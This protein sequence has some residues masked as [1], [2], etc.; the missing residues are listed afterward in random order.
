MK[1]RI[2]DKLINWMNDPR[3]KPLLVRG[4]RQVGKTFSIMEFGR[5]HYAGDL[6]VLNFEKNPE[7]NLIFDQNL[8]PKR[9]L[10][11]LE[12][13]LN[14][15]IRPGRDLIFFDEI[16]DCPK[17][18]SSLRYFYEEVQDLHVIA[19]GSLLEFA[20]KDISFPVG[21]LHILEM[22]PMDF[23]EFLIANGKELLAEE[24]SQTDSQLSNTVLDMTN[25]MLYNYFI[26]GGMPECVN[27][28]VT[29]GSLVQ[30]IDIQADLIATFRQ[31]FSKYAV[32]SDKRCLNSILNSVA[33]KTGEQIKY[34]K[35]DDTF[36]NP[37]IKKAFELLETARLFTKVRAASPAGMPLGAGASE[38]KFKTVFL[39]IGLLS[40]I[41][42]FYSDKN[43]SKDKFSSAYRGK[44]AEQFVGQEFR[45]A[46]R[47]LYYWSREAR[48]SNAETDYII[49]KDGE[50]VPVEVK[51]GKSGSLKSLHLMLSTFPNIKTAYVL[52]EDKFGK[53]E[54]KGIHFLP[55]CLAGSI[56]SRE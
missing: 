1:R 38:K 29:T 24:I 3:R 20:L 17:A 10:S 5:K 15:R 43:I 42:G 31:D 46:N 34:S 48:G 30:T 49:E 50:I 6:H 54:E 26:V 19:A 36:T 47:K 33:L 28:F 56:Y 14:K 27:T 44:M 52:T 13:F 45:A 11:E 22:H 12:L 9:I 25:S 18:I 2:T 40:Y 8:D 37:T 39:D 7:L 41:S 16:Q 21:R 55:L 23:R 35:L 4:A 51:S 32:H 53:L